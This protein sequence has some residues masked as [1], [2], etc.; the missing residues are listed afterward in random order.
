MSFLFPLILFFVVFSSIAWRHFYTALGL[1]IFI[2]PAYIIRFS[3]GPLPTTALEIAFGIIFLTWLTRLILFTNHPINF[4]KTFFKKDPIFWCGVILTIAA[5]LSCIWA[6]D[7]RA[8]L[9][10]WKAYFVEPLLFYIILVSSIQ[11]KEQ[12]QNLIM[13]AGGTVLILTI[14]AAIQYLTGWWLPTYEWSVAGMRR[15]T[16]V[17]TSPNALGLYVTPI[18]L[19]SLGLLRSKTTSIKS[20]VK[21]PQSLWLLL[22][23]A[24]ALTCLLLSVSKGAIIA[25]LTALVFFGFFAWSKKYTTIITIIALLIVFAMPSLR[26]PITTLATFQNLSGQSRV[27]LYQGTFDLLIQSPVKGL[28]LASFGQKFEDK[29]P[30]GYTEELIYPHNIFLNFWSETGLLGLVV[31]V[32]MMYFISL[33]FIN[34]KSSDALTIAL[35]AGFVAIFVHG[36][37]DV[38]YFKNDLALL[39][40]LLLAMLAWS[41]LRKPV[42]KP[43]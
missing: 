31:I 4:L 35:Y 23:I 15:S 27:A 22:V 9:G 10:I 39:T 43:E 3:I 20:L 33:A 14:L 7:L 1:F 6:T 11:K 34:R 38:P 12:W 16:A 37:V 18:L 40:W 8:A 13:Y 21:K 2:L 25:T 30:A 28:G 24:S 5:A 26:K 19:L 32:G 29:R 17:F 42:N 41:N 36:L